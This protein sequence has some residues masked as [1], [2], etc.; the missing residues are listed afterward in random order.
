[1][2]LFLFLVPVALGVLS[3]G[4]T[5]TNLAI[6]PYFA[7]I[8][9]NAAA[10]RYQEFDTRF[11]SGPDGRDSTKIVVDFLE[12]RKSQEWA[13]RATICLQGSDPKRAQLCF[14]LFVS[15]D[16]KTVTPTRGE[17][18]SWDDKEQNK[19]YYPPQPFADGKFNVLMEFDNGK[20][21][22]S[23]N[24]LPLFE[25]LHI[26]SPERYAFSCSTSLCRVTIQ[27]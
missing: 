26:R 22:F 10:G 20:T 14:G 25:S 3:T 21:T 23:L 13:P 12:L 27:E 8:E 18:L 4:C 9:I 6:E 15:R 19:Q 5:T 7:R 17:T 24:G 2:R 16:G 11:R 1:M